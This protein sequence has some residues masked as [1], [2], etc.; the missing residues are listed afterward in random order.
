MLV[1][2]SFV[3][4]LEKEDALRVAAEFLRVL[5]FS[6]PVRTESRLL[7]RRGL[8]K[9]KGNVSFIDL[10]QT[11]ELEFDRGRVAVAASLQEYGKVHDAQRQLVIGVV[12]GLESLLVRFVDPTDARALHDEAFQRVD[13]EFRR[14]KQSRRA[15]VICLLI[16]LAGVFVLLIWLANTV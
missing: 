15:L 11:V 9:P 6:D 13:A 4:T 7:A 14:R 5:G 2:H 12:R 1:E 8:A 10:P 3:T 16:F